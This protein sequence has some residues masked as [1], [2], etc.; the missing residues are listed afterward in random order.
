MRLKE[1]QYLAAVAELGCLLCDRIGYQGT[2][3]EIHHPRLD[4]GMSERGSSFT[5][6]PLCPEHHRGPHGIHGDR[7]AFKNARVT[8]M[9]LLAEVNERLW[10]RS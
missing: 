4:Q 8:E 10:C 5:T 6:I 7:E 9:D 1:A 3:A 2:P